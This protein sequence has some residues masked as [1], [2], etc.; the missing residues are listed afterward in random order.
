VNASTHAHDDA[1]AAHDTPPADIAAVPVQAGARL[2]MLFR[3]GL[4]A[5]ELNP[6]LYI[7]QRYRDRRS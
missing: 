4:T 5:G 6:L 2:L 3:R 1:P 7:V